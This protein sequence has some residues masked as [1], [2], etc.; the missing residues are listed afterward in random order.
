[1]LRGIALKDFV[2]KPYTV[3]VSVAEYPNC[4]FKGSFISRLGPAETMEEAI[5]MIAADRKAMGNT[6]DGLFEPV[7]V[8]GRTYAIFKAEWSRAE[9]AVA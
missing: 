9:M 2:P 5:E 8:K 4:G 7:S 6:Y 1:M 3:F